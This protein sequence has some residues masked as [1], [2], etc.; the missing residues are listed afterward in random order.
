VRVTFVLPSY[1]NQPIGGFRIVYQY[2]NALSRLGHEVSVAHTT[3]LAPPPPA[4]FPRVLRLG[5]RQ[6]LAARRVKFPPKIKWQ[7]L[8][9]NVRLI[10][11]PWGLDEDRLPDADF[12]F[13]TLW[14]TAELVRRLPPQK[15][16][17]CYLIQHWETWS[18]E[19]NDDLVGA[20]WK[21]PLHK[22][23]ISRWLYEKGVDLGADDMIHIPNALDHNRFR[24][25]TATESRPLRVVALNHFADWKGTS[26]ALVALEMLH[27]SH[28]EVGISLFGTPSKPSKLPLWIRYYENPSQEVL[29]REVYNGHAIYLGASW[30]EGWALPPAEAMACGCAFVGTDIGGYRDYAIDGETALL[31]PP[32][33]PAALYRNLLRVVEDPKLLRRIQERGTEYIQEFTWERSGRA[34]EDWLLSLRTKNRSS[35]QRLSQ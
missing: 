10:Y 3:L 17:H 14:K 23:V 20:T 1:P 11:L 33:D 2:A 21:L 24:V 6:L 18:P 35:A 8:E 31:S 26:D 9:S 29:V 12:V 16:E 22:V 27:D 34:M 5:W 15:G 19:A 32:K 13:A 28:P 4:T 25:C 7:Q 30:T